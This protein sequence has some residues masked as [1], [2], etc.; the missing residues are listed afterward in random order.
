MSDE[1]DRLLAVYSQNFPAYGNQEE[2]LEREHYG[3]FAVFRDGQLLGVYETV[4][5]AEAKIDEA[6]MSDEC[7]IFKIGKQPFRYAD[8][9]GCRSHSSVLR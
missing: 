5:D 4:E 9:M 1:V 6:A 3:K 7:A 2:R 8:A